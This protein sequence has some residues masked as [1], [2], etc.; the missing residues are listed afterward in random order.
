LAA[1]AD[2]TI[3]RTQRR[4]STIAPAGRPSIYVA[5]GPRGLETAVAG[6]IGSE[7]VDMLGARNVVSAA[8]APR[9]VVEV[10]PEQVLAWQPDVILAVDRRFRAS[11]ATD[12]VWR[13]LEAVRKKHVYFVPELPFSWLDD[14]PAPNRL[15][16]LAWLG[17]RL[18][19]SLFPEDIRA[20]ARRFYASFYGQQPSDAQIDG[21][22][23]NPPI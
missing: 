17:S 21:L 23:A 7:V 10:S 6:S 20:E 19:P 14:P 15:I 4:V 2:E 1:F 11:I 5:R 12:P 22:L 3:S 8:T 9:T 16:G 18:Y 13:Q